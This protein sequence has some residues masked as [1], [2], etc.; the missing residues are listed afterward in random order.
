MLSALTFRIRTSGQKKKKCEPTSKISFN[1]CIFGVKV[2][3]KTAIKIRQVY[4]A[5]D[6]NLLVQNCEPARIWL[7]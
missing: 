3:L 6:W 4:I 7:W 1:Q 5:F 2:D